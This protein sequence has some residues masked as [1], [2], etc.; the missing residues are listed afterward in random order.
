MG[1]TTQLDFTIGYLPDGLK[2]ETDGPV[3]WVCD[4][5]GL[6]V[7]QTYTVHTA[8]GVGL[9]WI[10]RAI[11]GDRILEVETP[12][13]A[14]ESMTLNGSTAILVHP[15][16]DETGLGY[17]GV[18]IPEDNVGPEFTILSVTSDNAIPFDELVKF[19]EGLK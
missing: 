6:V 11:T 18:F 15:A 5:E 13:D 3:K 7:S 2:Y 14:V 4:S 17:G 9:I 8:L 19:A 1:A 12:A 16:D 10:E